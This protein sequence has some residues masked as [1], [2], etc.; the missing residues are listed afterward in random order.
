MRESEEFIHQVVTFCDE[1][2]AVVKA[3]TAPADVY[4]TGKLSQRHFRQAL[5]H[6]GENAVSGPLVSYLEKL[7]SDLRFSFHQTPKP[8]PGAVLRY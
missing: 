2:P 4:T 6:G 1:Q 8:T 3:D 5:G 7:T